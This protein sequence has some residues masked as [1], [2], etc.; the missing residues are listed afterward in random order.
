MLLDRKMTALKIFA[1]TVSMIGLL[2]AFPAASAQDMGSL[3]ERV[4]HLIAGIDGQVGV[5]IRHIE[6]GEG[7]NVNGDRLFPTASVY[8]VP[9]MVEVFRQAHEGKFSV[10]DRIT[11]EPDSLYFSTILSHFEPGL[12]PTIHDIMFW[13]ITESENGATDLL[14]TKVGPENVTATMR[15]LGLKQITVSRTVKIMMCDY[16]GFYDAPTRNLTGKEFRDM[17]DRKAN[18]AYY[19]MWDDKDAPVPESVQKFNRDIKDAASP[20]DVSALLEMIFQG[21]VV[22]KEASQDM[23]AI[24][25]QT[26]FFPQL[27]K[28]QLP[29]GTPV[30]RKA[31]TL[32]TTLNETGI[33]YL[34]NDKG[35]V[36]VTV[37]TND[38]R[39]TRESK[40]NLISGIARAAYDYF[41]TPIGPAH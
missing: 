40:Q 30:A 37:M 38:L 9:I 41:V 33:I 35:H 1:S 39:G 15:S 36:I 28:G 31:G 21:K 19:K 23:I 8:K 11:L 16:M 24:M 17:W 14:L 27:I 26:T 32:P 4:Q 18:T 34:P 3:R 25:L 2:F 12:N 6:S 29:W 10:H 20:N 22:D 5:T 7:F 13:M